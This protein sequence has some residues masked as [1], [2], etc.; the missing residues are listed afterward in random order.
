MLIYFY[1]QR[2]RFIISENCRAV[3]FNTKCILL[4]KKWKFKSEHSL[5]S[6]MLV[7]S[8]P[9]QSL[10]AIH[11][12]T[13]FIPYNSSKDGASQQKAFFTQNVF[14][15]I[16][17]MS[18][19]SQKDLVQVLTTHNNEYLQ[20]LQIMVKVSRVCLLNTPLLYNS[21]ARNTMYLLLQ[22]SGPP[23]LGWTPAEER[24]YQFRIFSFPVTESQLELRKSDKL[25]NSQNL[26]NS[27]TVPGKLWQRQIHGA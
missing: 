1:L 18:R 23:K 26:R 12:P 8:F 7:S 21:P 5:F 3:T 9:F 6:Q 17:K 16:K 11:F 27:Q 4:Q 22:H 14:S 25:I 19:G 2:F 15:R 20:K 24:E 10:C 13:V